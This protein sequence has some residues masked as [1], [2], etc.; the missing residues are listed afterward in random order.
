MNQLSDDKRNITIMRVIG[1][2]I[3][4]I[5]LYFFIQEV[6]YI[7]ISILLAV[8]FTLL[9]TK[10]LLGYVST[11]RQIYPFIVDFKI[12]LLSIS[13]TLFTIVISHIISML[14]VNKWK[15]V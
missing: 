11:N 10:S 5:S 3:R 1:F 4:D 8:P 13:F 14:K 12:I 2:R 9:L 7:I 6:F 15:M